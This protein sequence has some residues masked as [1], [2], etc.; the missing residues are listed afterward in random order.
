MIDEEQKKGRDVKEV[1][2]V[3]MIHANVLCGSWKAKIQSKVNCSSMSSDSSQHGNSSS[4]PA[5][6]SSHGICMY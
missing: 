4:R 2:I 1:K 5:F 6:D 3:S